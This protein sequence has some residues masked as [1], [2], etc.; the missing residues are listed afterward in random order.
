MNRKRGGYLVSDDPELADYAYITRSLQSTYWAAGRD[1]DAVRASA[2]GSLFLHMLKDGRQVGFAR[3]LSDGA[4]VALLLDVFI[5]PGLRGLGLG[6][7]L[8]ECVL[9]H[10][11][12]RVEKLNLFTTSAAGLYAKLGFES[13]PGGM[14]LK[15]KK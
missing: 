7:W 13:H 12:C 2:R 11:A 4:C 10:S 3:I 5:E 6:R 1:E 9:D 15:R 14:V 8:M